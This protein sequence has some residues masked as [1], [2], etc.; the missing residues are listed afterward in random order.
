MRKNINMEITKTVDLKNV[1][2]VHHGNMQKHIPS[3]QNYIQRN[4]SSVVPMLF[5]GNLAD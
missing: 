4:R 1:L 3:P 2:T 5:E